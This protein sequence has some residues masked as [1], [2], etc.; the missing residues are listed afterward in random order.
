MLLADLLAVAV[1]IPNP[2]S[3]IGKYLAIELHSNRATTL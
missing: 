3:E 2:M 1:A